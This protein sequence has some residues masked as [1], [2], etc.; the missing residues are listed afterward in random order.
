MLG[1]DKDR[2]GRP[3]KVD[4]TKE[5]MEEFFAVS[6]LETLKN[7]LEKNLKYTPK[8]FNFYGL[9]NHARE[10]FKIIQKKQR[11]FNKITK[12]IAPNPK[13]IIALGDAKFASTC[14]GLSSCPIA[15]VVEAL[16]RERQV[17]LI[18]ETNTT[19]KCSYCRSKS[20]IT[21]QG[22]SKRT[23]TSTSGKE[24]RVPIH[25][26]RHC[27]KCSQNVNRDKNAARGIFYS[28]KHHYKHGCLPAY[29][30]R[31]KRKVYS[32]KSESDDPISTNPS[33]RRCVNHEVKA[34]IYSNS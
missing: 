20:G 29:L 3:V 9:N 19:R 12:R 34:A 6:N 15:K 1:K 22:V 16:S 30:K 28:F 11:F 10:R 2:Y 5:K 27:T 8:I 23:A 33:K 17:V 7:K 14:K 18:P 13:T 24:Y 25:G 32:R 31:R 4:L 26:L 21:K